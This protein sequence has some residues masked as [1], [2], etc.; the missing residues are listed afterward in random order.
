MHSSRLCS[1]NTLVLLILWQLWVSESTSCRT[2]AKQPQ[3]IKKLKSK[4]NDVH[5]RLGDLETKVNGSNN[6][7]Y[8]LMQAAIGDKSLVKE[9]WIAHSSV[10]LD[11]LLLLCK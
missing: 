10:S 3:N 6:G 7:V 1:N 8:S 5:G 9:S 4:V 11:V 2:T